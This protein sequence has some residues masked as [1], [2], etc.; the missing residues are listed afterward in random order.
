[1][2]GDKIKMS[3][4]GYQIPPRAPASAEPARYPPV[5]SSPYQ[6]PPRVPAGER[7]VVLASNMGIRD[8]VLVIIRAL[9]ANPINIST[10]EKVLLWPQTTVRAKEIWILNAYSRLKADYDLEQGM[11]NLN[12]S[13]SE[14]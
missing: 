7:L 5:I 9:A 13:S 10:I 12:L 14:D 11:R 3:E 8:N 2:A 6:I 1:M 4:K